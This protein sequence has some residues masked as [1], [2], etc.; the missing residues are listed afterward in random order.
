MTDKPQDTERN[1]ESDVLKTT[2]SMRSKVMAIFQELAADRAQALEPTAV[3][4]GKMWELISSS[5]QDFALDEYRKNAKE[6]A[7]HMAD[8]SYDAAFIVAL[9]LFPERFTGEEIEAGITQFLGHVPEHVA[10][11][12]KLSGCPIEGI[13]ED[14]DSPK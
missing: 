7:F 1:G 8:W 12:A 9:H 13:F 6:I 2:D 3:C 4:D 14:S 10:V 5:W 11:A